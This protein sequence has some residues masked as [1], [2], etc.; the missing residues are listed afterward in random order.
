M[1]GSTYLARPVVL[2]SVT[3]EVVAAKGMSATTALIV[4]AIEIVFTSFPPFS[5]ISPIIST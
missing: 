2:T 4:P 5:P 3:K 1:L